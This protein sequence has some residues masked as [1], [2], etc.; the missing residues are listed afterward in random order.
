MLYNLTFN[1]IN[2]KNH[3]ID[4]TYVVNTFRSM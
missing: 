1:I 3:Y 2:S 4:Y